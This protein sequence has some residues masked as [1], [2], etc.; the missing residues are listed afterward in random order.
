MKELDCDKFWKDKFLKLHHLPYITKVM[1]MKK[2][3]GTAATIKENTNG[4]T[5]GRL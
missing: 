4:Q 1:W 2:E 3:Q 5:S